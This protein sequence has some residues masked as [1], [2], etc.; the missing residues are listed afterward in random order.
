MLEKTLESPLDSKEIKPA[1]P[2]GNKPWIFIERTDAEAEAPI[3]WPPDVKNL[4]LLPLLCPASSSVTDG[5]PVVPSTVSCSHADHLT[6]GRQ[7]WL[8]GFKITAPRSEGPHTGLVL[9]CSHLETQQFL[10]TGPYIFM[11]WALQIMYPVSVTVFKEKS[12]WSSYVERE[13]AVSLGSV[14][15]N[16]MMDGLCHCGSQERWGLCWHSLLSAPDLLSKS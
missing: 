1:N 4:L 6:C 13:S 5:F 11:H 10:N 8:C 14:G 2:K 15:V 3:L 12:I 16:S 7:G 9:S